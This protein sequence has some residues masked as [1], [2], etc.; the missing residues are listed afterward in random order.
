MIFPRSYRRPQL[1][2]EGCAPRV[3]LCLACHKGDAQQTQSNEQTGAQTG[4]IAGVT[5][6]Q[7]QA[8]GG[9]A[10]LPR[11]GSNDAPIMGGPPGA[12]DNA[13]GSTQAV[14]IN[15]NDPTQM[16]NA[17]D[18]VTN[19]TNTS[20]DSAKTIAQAVIANSSSTN[21]LLKEVGAY[22]ALAGC[23]WLAFKIFAKNK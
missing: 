9:G 6:T 2:H 19:A 17:L 15:T 5:I 3:A 4:A 8:G 1:E 13:G 16:Q 21:S 22:G 20:T 12:G 7:N 18:A 10:I 14:T 23:G 11:R